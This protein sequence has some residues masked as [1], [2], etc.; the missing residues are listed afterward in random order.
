MEG[1]K[2]LLQKIARINK[3]IKPKLKEIKDTKEILSK[4]KLGI[5]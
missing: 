1:E 3:E 4:I 5:S 2:R